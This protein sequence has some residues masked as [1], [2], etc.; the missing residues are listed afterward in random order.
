VILIGGGAVAYGIKERLRASGLLA[1]ASKSP[2][3]AG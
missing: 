2:E 3:P 1:G